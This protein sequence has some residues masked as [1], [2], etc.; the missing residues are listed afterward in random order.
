MSFSRL[1]QSLGYY[2]SKKK[3]KI[4]IILQ[5]G[6]LFV[7]IFY[8]IYVSFFLLQPCCNN[9]NLKFIHFVFLYF[10]AGY[11]LLD[12][13]QLHLHL[14]CH[15]LPKN[16]VVIVFSLLGFHIMQSESINKWNYP[17]GFKKHLTVNKKRNFIPSR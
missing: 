3:K 7:S 8:V 11:I 16:Q 10:F 4:C 9:T 2:S 5:G 13:V 15:G 1:R 6:C 12:F 14:S 17:D